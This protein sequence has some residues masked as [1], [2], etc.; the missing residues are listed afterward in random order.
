LEEYKLIIVFIKNEHLDR[1]DR[2]PPPVSRPS[3]VK[4]EGNVVAYTLQIN[5]GN[6]EALTRLSAS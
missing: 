2:M 4:P 5:V 1:K 3:S 6:N